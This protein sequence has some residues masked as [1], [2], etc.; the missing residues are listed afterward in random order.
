MG[1]TEDLDAL[2][3][4]ARKELGL[5][6][7]GQEEGYY[8]GKIVAFVKAIEL[9]EKGEPDEKKK[10][11]INEFRCEKCN[12]LLAKFTTDIEFRD[13]TPN[14]T[15]VVEGE[16]DKP[17]KHHWILEIKCPRCDKIN[18]MPISEKYAPIHTD[19]KEQKSAWIAFKQKANLYVKNI[20][21]PEALN[22]VSGNGNNL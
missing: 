6:Q 15:F 17:W 16:P 19:E 21:A 8:S 2:L 3:A 7:P 10:M 12:K 22:E 14:R 11:T 4:E 20:E 13:D 18:Q 5:C 1:T 9:I